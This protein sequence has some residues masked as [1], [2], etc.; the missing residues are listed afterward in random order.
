MPSKSTSRKPASPSAAKRSSRSTSGSASRSRT[1]TS[2]GARRA[3]SGGADILSLLKKDHATVDKMFKSYDRMK[4]GDARKQAL[5]E[6]I[7]TELTVHAKAEE[8]LFY[9]ALRNALDA[10]AKGI[11][12]LD[13]AHVE[14][15]TFKWLIAALE[16]QS[17]DEAT[18]DAQV[19][20]LGEYVKHHVKEEEGEIFKTARKAG[21]D[22]AELGS[23]FTA[24]KKELKSESSGMPGR[25]MASGNGG[26]R[27]LR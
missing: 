15:D 17:G 2:T 24:R 21:I 25:A 10:G 9:P 5:R 8:E 12:L 3:R 18:T 22:L 1:R 4:E 6:Q 16:E 7:L 11:E 13:E 27:A 20:V 14:H 19:K 26:D 23:A